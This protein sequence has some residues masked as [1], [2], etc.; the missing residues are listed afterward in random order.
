MSNPTGPSGRRV[1]I[2]RMGAPFRDIALTNG[3]S[4]R[5]Y[6]TS[7]PDVPIGQPYPKLR[8]PWVAAREARGDRN[9][10]QMHYA[11]RGEITEEMWFI[12]ER[13]GM[14]PDFVR[15]EVARGR[16]IIP[17]NKRHLELEP[18]I[19]GRRFRVK[20]NANIGNSAVTSSIAEEVEKLRWSTR[21][22]ADTVMDLSTGPAIRETRESIL[23]HSPVPIG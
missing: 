5:Q 10:S 11:R 8:A 2:G 12:A 6:D 1:T 23:R 4:F 9:F 13:E 15:S 14:E 3:E 7:G 20:V 17:A 21:W 18:M 16:A 22:G 19:I